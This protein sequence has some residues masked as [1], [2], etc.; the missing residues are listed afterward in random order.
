[1]DAKLVK[2]YYRRMEANIAMQNYKL[3]QEDAQKLVELVPTNIQ[4]KEKLEYVEQKVSQSEKER[5]R[6]KYI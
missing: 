6:V 1:M 5:G 2:A 3:A 4:F